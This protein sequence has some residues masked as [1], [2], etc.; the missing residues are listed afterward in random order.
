MARLWQRQPPAQNPIPAQSASPLSVVNDRAAPW[1][2]QGAAPDSPAAPLPMPEPAAQLAPLPVKS[3]PL[4]ELPLLLDVGA[5]IET[6]EGQAPE[7]GGGAC[8]RASLLLWPADSEFALVGYLQGQDGKRVCAKVDLTAAMLPPDAP[9]ASDIVHEA[10]P[11]AAA[12]AATVAPADIDEPAPRAAA[13]V[14]K[15]A[16]KKG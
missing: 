4:P 6:R 9:P 16:R 2:Y 10:A 11:L 14:A 8:Y 1:P 5:A 15:A 7:F 3:A 13:A 12:A